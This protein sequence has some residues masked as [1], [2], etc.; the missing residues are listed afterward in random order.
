MKVLVESWKNA[1]EEH[2][3]SVKLLAN[4]DFHTLIPCHFI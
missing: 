4:K 1:S 2:K 3:Q